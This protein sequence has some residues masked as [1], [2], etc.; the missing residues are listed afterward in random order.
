MYATAA[1]EMD[2]DEIADRLAEEARAAGFKHEAENWM[3][4]LFILLDEPASGIPATLFSLFILVLIAA[5]STCFLAESHPQFRCDTDEFCEEWGTTK[6][7]AEAWR[8]IF[9]ITEWISIVV[10]T[11]EYTL[12]MMVCSWRPR[13]N[14]SFLKYFKKGL[15]IVDLLA[16]VPF[17]VEHLLCK[18]PDGQCNSG[19]SVIRILRLARIFR[20][21]KAGNFANELQVFIWGYYRARE[22]LLLLFFLLFLYLCLFAALLYMSEYDAQSEACFTEAGYSMCW[23]DLGRD[24]LPQYTDGGGVRVQEDDGVDQKV[25]AWDLVV[26]RG[27]D[28]NHCLGNTLFTCNG[29]L[30][31]GTA[32]QFGMYE[33]VLLCA[34]EPDGTTWLNTTD[35]VQCNSDHP[36]FVKMTAENNP[37]FCML[38][39][40]VQWPGKEPMRCHVRPFTSIPTT[41]YF[42]MATM[43]TVRL[44]SRWR[45]LLVAAHR[46]PYMHTCICCVQVG[47]GEHYPGSVAGQI[48]CSACMLCGV[49]VLAL[50]LIIIGNAFEETVKEEERYKRE[51]QKRMEIKLL[52]RFGGAN[53]LA[54]QV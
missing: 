37:D 19:A 48:V 5:S 44:D 42:I 6:E 22:G 50:P 28:C 21:M 18:G 35:D 36:N 9:H 3:Q 27:E 4:S 40:D 30:L 24:I 15:N 34:D 8:D 16:I 41:W 47:Y 7:D 43:T 31:N 13:A 45:C 1:K 39:D 26:E 32:V 23:Q 33:D 25:V 53:D 52:E 38:C 12:R 54:N 51:R 20:V 10:F 49:I 2:E 29:E 14:R 17:W 46:S 11:I